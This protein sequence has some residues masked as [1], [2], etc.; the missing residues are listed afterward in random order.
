MRERLSQSR[1]LSQQCVNRVFSLEGERLSFTQPLE[2]IQRKVG[3]IATQP[4][5]LSAAKASQIKL[6]RNVS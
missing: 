2:T 5:V 1:S 4:A 6:L 3:S